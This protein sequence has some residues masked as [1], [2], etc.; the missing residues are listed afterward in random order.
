MPYFQSRPWP[1]FT[2]DDSSYD[3]SHLDEYSFKLADSK[4][5][6]RTVVVT[7][8]DHCFT[9]KWEASDQHS[10]RFPNCSRKPQGAFCQV[11]YMHS[12]KLREYIGQAILGDVWIADGEGFAII[13]I[14]D[15]QGIRVLYCILFDL[16][17]IHELPFELRMIV[18]TAYPLDSGRNFATNGNIRFRHLVTL[19]IE[20][21]RPPRNTDQ[22]RKRPQI[23]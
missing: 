16:V 7:F 18:R 4:G 15:G 10:L 20:G 22:R 14:V 6:Y 8:E 11:R 21:K 3:L 19:K 17:K 12:L 13:P 9:R 5:V 2:L 1:L 23:K